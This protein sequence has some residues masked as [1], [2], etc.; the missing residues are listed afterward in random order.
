MANNISERREM[1]KDDFQFQAEWR[2]QKSIEYPEDRRN[3]D[4]HNILLRIASTVDSLTDEEIQTFYDE[5]DS[6]GPLD[7]CEKWNEMLRRVGF[8]SAPDHAREMLHEFI[9]DML[10]CDA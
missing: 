5:F 9:N 8:S 6:D 7:A 1:L 3:I 4:A 10:E 2:K